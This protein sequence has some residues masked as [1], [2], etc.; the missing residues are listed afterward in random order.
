MN[1]KDIIENFTLGEI[2]A[3]YLNIIFTILSIYIHI[4]IF[5]LLL[6]LN[7]LQL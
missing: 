3:F 6:V 5:I 4:K 2:H 7:I 1:K